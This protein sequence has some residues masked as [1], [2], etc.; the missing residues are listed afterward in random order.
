MPDNSTHSSDRPAPTGG[1]GFRYSLC[2]FAVVCVVLG[3]VLGL[4]GIVLNQARQ[5]RR[6]VEAISRLGGQVYYVD[7]YALGGP[8]WVRRTSLGHDLLLTVF[9]V[10]IDGPR[11]TDHEMPELSEHLAHPH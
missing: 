2:T 3:L 9:K 7:R 6:A 4:L 11:V 10:H 8:E 5:E 1:R